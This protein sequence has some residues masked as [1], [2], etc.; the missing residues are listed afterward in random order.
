MPHTID[1]RFLGRPGVIATAVIVG[2]DG[3]ALVDPGPAS[4]LPA[5]VE[6]LAAHGLTLDDVRA[7]L[8]THI[9]LDHAGATGTLCRRRPGL[10]VYVQA[11]GAQHLAQPEKLLASAM[12]LYGAD[13]DRLWGEFL[14]VPAASLRPLK[15]GETIDL[16]GR[17]V[18]VAY[19]PGHAVHHVTYL[20]PFDRTAYVGDTA[21]IRVSGDYALPAT[22]PPDID[23]ARWLESLGVIEAW[24]PSALFLTHFGLVG[25]AAAHLARYR[26]ALVR[27]ATV[28]RD[29]LRAGGDDAA[30]T[31]SWV[32]WLRHD[33]RT[34][35]SEEAA[36]AAEAAAP[37]EQVWQGLVRYWRKRV[38]RE[39]PGALD[40]P[41]A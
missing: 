20:D 3:V 30:L 21:G 22:P 9:H 7:V 35:L 37:F 2:N 28:A 10:P 4:C 36:Q 19:T 13:M 11:F 29:L 16:G 23:I 32:D 27:A 8:L 6:G 25:D 17:V 26:A 12:R 40:A 31:V 18:E 5:L 38:E 33:V 41:P 15:G 14:A 39:G 24:A 34:E 1:L